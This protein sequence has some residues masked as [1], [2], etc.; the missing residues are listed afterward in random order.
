ML[1]VNI[2]IVIILSVNIISYVVLLS[3]IML[4]VI[5]LNGVILVVIILSFCPSISV[6]FT[7][8]YC[9]IVEDFYKSQE[10]YKLLW[11]FNV[12]R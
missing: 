1:I 11:E 7:D 4:R 10:L 12:S 6:I 3:I 9:P 8:N 2:F 5:M